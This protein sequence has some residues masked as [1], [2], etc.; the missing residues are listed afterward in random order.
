MSEI[1]YSFVVVLDR[2][3]PI[4][5]LRLALRKFPF[6][7]LLKRFIRNQYYASKNKSAFIKKTLFVYGWNHEVTVKIGSLR[8]CA[9]VFGKTLRQFCGAVGRDQ[10]V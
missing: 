3:P 8:F 10:Q 5:V 9:A 7:I 4:G 1:P 6:N 2:R